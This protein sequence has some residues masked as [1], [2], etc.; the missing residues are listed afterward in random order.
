MNRELRC[1]SALLLFTTS[2]QAQA[3]RVGK[4][5]IEPLD[6][7]SRAEENRGSFYRLADRL[8]IET[9]R[10]VIAKFLLFHEGDVYQPARLEE[11]ER[12]LRALEIGRASCRERVS[13]HV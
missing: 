3:L 2:L 9:H 6:V 5:T 4:I 11:T 1:L 10:N 13:Y 8:H 12:N 7:Y